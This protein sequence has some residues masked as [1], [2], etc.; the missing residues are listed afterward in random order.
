MLLEK[1]ASPNARDC[2][3]RTPLFK[4]ENLIDIGKILLEHGADVNARDNNGWTPLMA[5]I[6]LGSVEMVKFLSEHDADWGA[7]SKFGTHTVD[8]L[9][10]NADEPVIDYYRQHVARR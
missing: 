10:I 1:G 3:G 5:A 8:D 7:T 9:L 4:I 6:R 2:T